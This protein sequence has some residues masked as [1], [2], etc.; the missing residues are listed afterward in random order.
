MA[1]WSADMMACRFRTGAVGGRVHAWFESE[2]AAGSPEVVLGVADMLIGADLSPDLERIRCPVLLLAPDGSPF[3][4]A[5][6][7]AEMHA[8]ISTSEMQ[9]FADAR[10]G[11][12]CSH[13]QQCADALRQFLSRHAS[14]CGAST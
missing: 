10:H 13:G 11:L 7:T 4:A 12:A 9:I 2:Q 14:G 1:A 6:V 8:M 5:N 3:V